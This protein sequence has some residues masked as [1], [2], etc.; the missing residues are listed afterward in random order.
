M[1]IVREWITARKRRQAA[2]A[3]LE[4]AF[5]LFKDPEVRAVIAEKRILRT[6]ELERLR[7]SQILQDYERRDAS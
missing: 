5:E 4:A 6:Q 2:K 7:V 3:R 1:G